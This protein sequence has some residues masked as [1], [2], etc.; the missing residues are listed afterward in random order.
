MAENCIDY[1]RRKEISDKILTLRNEGAIEES[2][3]ICVDF[4]KNHPKYFYFFKILGDL[5]F[6]AKKY[7]ESS[8]SYIEFLT[9][10]PA[11]KQ[12]FSEFANRYFRLKRVM[13]EEQIASIAWRVHNT[14]CSGDIHP[15]LCSL[16]E[17]LVKS[18]LRE[19]INRTQIGINLEELIINNAKLADINSLSRKLETENPLELELILNTIIL[20]RNR[21]IKDYQIDSY[22]ISLY[23]RLGNYEDAA[24]ISEELLEVKLDQV[25]VRSLF[26]LCRKMGKYDRA[27]R[28]IN[29]HKSIFTDTSFNVL[30]ELVYYYEY[31]DDFESI[32]STLSRIEKNGIS[33]LPIQKTVKNFYLRF[34]LLDDAERVEH[35][36]KEFGSDL[37]KKIDGKF[38]DEVFETEAG[39]ET[40]IKQLYSKIEHQ[41]RLAAISDLTTGISHELGQPI[42]NIRYTIQFYS[43]MLEQNF[44]RSLVTKVFTSILEETERMG[45]LIKRLAPISS[46]KNVT[47]LFDVSDQ[48]HKRVT[49]EEAKLLASNI[50]VEIL[51]KQR[52]LYYGDPVKFDQIIANLLLN[53]IDAI[54][55]KGAKSTNHI[56]IQISKNA[57]DLI[58]IVSDTG[59]GITPKNRGKI[60]DPFF[61]TKSPGKG[62]GLGLFIVWNILKMVGGKIRIDH[63]YSNGTRFILNLPITK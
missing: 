13:S 35:R 53:A 39:V 6:Q 56:S 31:L 8:L 55:E 16:S 49:S 12:L 60:F 36:L 17:E 63:K 18:D 43:K 24:K 47:E 2:I 29:A 42:T 40:K 9:K 34:G 11:S 51:F 14:A 44:D 7:E 23:E 21:S 46:T 19:N 52:I 38:V 3:N 10:I 22:C 26:R 4:T 28:A 41:A 48:I 54:N 30:Y 61:S 15:K 20:N 5:Y 33:S 62:E 58:I 50:E 45:R 37:S 57:N 32:Q 27:D 25:V 59:I 1:T